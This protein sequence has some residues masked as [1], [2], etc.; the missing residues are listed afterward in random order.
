MNG[1]FTESIVDEA[2][3]AWLEAVGYAVLYGPDIAAGELGTERR[4]PNYRGVA[5]KTLI[6][7]E[8]RV[9]DLSALAGAAA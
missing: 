5:P 9:K 7:G 1:I 3:L 4:D 6:S 8:L 2:T